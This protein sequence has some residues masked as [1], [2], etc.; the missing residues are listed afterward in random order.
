METTEKRIIEINGMKMEV[1]LR[2]AKRIDE[3]KLGDNVK[4]MEKDG[5]NYKILPGVIIEFVEFKEL[6][7]IQIAV[8]ETSYWGSAIRFIN[9]NSESKD[10]EIT[11][12]SEHELVL[13][14]NRIIDKMNMDIDKKKGEYLEA[15][16]KKDYL[17]KHFGKY[18]KEI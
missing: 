1:D 13:E 15:V 4:V 14:K 11:S 10:V 16:A 8:F 5:S 6:P 9:F 18:F 17:I 3:F 7:T 12:V 2:A